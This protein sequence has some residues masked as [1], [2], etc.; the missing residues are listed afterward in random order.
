MPTTFE[1]ILV[2]QS[3]TLWVVDDP[4]N[5][6][7]GNLW[8]YVGGTWTEVI[9]AKNAR[10]ISAVAVDPANSSHVFAADYHG[11]ISYSTNAGR[12]FGIA[13]K[14]T[15]ISA[16][17]P[18]MATA[19]D[20]SIAVAAL[21][22][23]PTQ[24]S[25]LYAAGGTGVWS[26]TP[27]TSGSV[28]TWDG[29]P[30]V[31]I[32]NLV[33]TIGVSPPGGPMML[34]AWDRALWLINN[35]GS[36]QSNYLPFYNPS[37]FI[38]PGWSVSYNISSPTTL[39]VLDQSRGLA[40]STGNG[41]VGSWR[42][43]SSLPS[44]FPQTGLGGNF[45]AYSDTSA[46]WVMGGAPG[47]PYCLIGGSITSSP[48]WSRCTFNNGT[49]V[50]GG[51]WIENYR[52]TKWTIAVD[53]MAAHTYCLYNDGSGTNKAGFYESTDG[54][55][56]FLQA[57]TGSVEGGN[58][59]SLFAVPGQRGHFFAASAPNVHGRL[60]DANIHLWR[61]ANGCGGRWSKVAN[62]ESV[63]GFGFGKAGPGGD[64]YPALYCACWVNKGR[65]YTYGIWRADNIDGPSPTWTQVGDGF[66]N[67]NF[68]WIK[69]VTGDMNVYG[70]VYIGFDG[71]GFAY[72]DLD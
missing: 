38:D 65:G 53:T 6:N 56:F 30:T 33:A 39:Y 57:A 47:G 45:V 10:H 48:V 69:F 52:L 46:V 32:E 19:N 28:V 35:P 37:G 63:F 2:D 49:T 40:Y 3:G 68:D 72:R 34:A 23:D 8:K 66:P 26:T 64:G 60:P 24:S 18:W 31:G 50:D 58:Q 22:F 62:V 13:A 1:N 42:V 51:G 5:S 25:V 61:T 59:F 16:A 11:Y 21:A 54:R 29:S 27:P 7:N 12:S 14:M 15:E 43:P 44:A 70:R 36:P 71:S 67:G 17:N 41:A 4:T 55:A 9:S 20:S